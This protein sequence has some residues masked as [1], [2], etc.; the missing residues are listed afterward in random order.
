MHIDLDVVNIAYFSLQAIIQTV[1]EH[2][3]QQYWLCYN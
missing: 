1:V 2:I 3:P